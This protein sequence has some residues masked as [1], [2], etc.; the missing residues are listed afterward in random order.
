MSEFDR[1]YKTDGINSHQNMWALH[2]LQWKA[3]VHETVAGG[4]FNEGLISQAELD[5][6]AYPLTVASESCN[7]RANFLNDLESRPNVYTSNTG[8]PVDPNGSW[9]CVDESDLAFVNVNPSL[10]GA[11]IA[12][13]NMHFWKTPTYVDIS[14]G[15]FCHA[16]APAQ[17]SIEQTHATKAVIGK[18]TLCTKHDDPNTPP[19][20]PPTT[21]CGW[22]SAS[23][24]NLIDISD[25]CENN[26]DLYSVTFSFFS[27]FGEYF[28]Q[29]LYTSSPAVW[30]SIYG[31]PSTLVFDPPPG[32]TNEDIQNLV[33]AADM[34]SGARVR[35]K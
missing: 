13:L 7:V 28:N 14:G 18:V 20:P 12:A 2:A 31:P 27:D 1:D 5:S 33:E 6:Q 3:Y 25:D 29:D 24:S 16:V 22:N 11:I 9:L 30:A 17:C 23:W 34:A 35:R 8:A 19:P 21:V 4:S 10:E 26:I 32:V 15:G